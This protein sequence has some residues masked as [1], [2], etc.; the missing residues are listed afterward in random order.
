MLLA[1]SL[2]TVN[3]IFIVIIKYPFENQVILD[4]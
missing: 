3:K 1:L 4:T 2:T